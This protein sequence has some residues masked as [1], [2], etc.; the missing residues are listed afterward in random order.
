MATKTNAT[1]YRTSNMCAFGIGHLVARKE[2]ELK[3]RA[4]YPEILITRVS[5]FPAWVMG[6]HYEDGR[7]FRRFRTDADMLAFMERYGYE[8]IDV[9]TWGRK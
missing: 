3:A 1:P 8:L 7:I 6:A 9:D 4:K 2:A 5:I